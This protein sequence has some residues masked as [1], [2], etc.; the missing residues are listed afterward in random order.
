M[1]VKLDLYNG[2]V[3]AL[4]AITETTAT[5]GSKRSIETV[6]IWNNQFDRESEEIAFNFPAI[7][8]EFASIPWT[9]T[10]QQPI[11]SGSNASNI[12]K[13]QKAPGTL[14][15]LHC[16][17]S[18]LDNATDSFP[19]IEPILEKIY[20]AIQGVEVNHATAL[21]R[22]EERQ[23]TEHSRVID[24]QI[25]F[26]TML[27]QAGQADSDLTLIPADTLILETT[28]DLDIEPTTKG[29]IRTGPE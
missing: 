27:I 23:D 28:E 6:G 5:D 8:I 17:F 24:W 2:I 25:D 1:G 3:T 9:T 7:F 10:N 11:R 26:S 22:G 29:D 13:E 16:G 15:T 20:F 19:I 18:E 12:S 14:L 4:K 21:L